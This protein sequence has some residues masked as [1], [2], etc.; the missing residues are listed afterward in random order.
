MCAT[1]LLLLSVA[2]ATPVAA[3]YVPIELVTL[4][5]GTSNVVRAVNDGG[6]VAAATSGRA[7]LLTRTG[8]QLFQDPAAT[9]YSVALGINA[10]GE[11]VGFFNTTSAVRAFRG[12]R[13]AG[14]VPLTPL[15]GDSASQAFAINAAG[16]AV[17]FSSGPAG[18]RAVLWSRSG[19]VQEL[20]VLLPA[21]AATRALAINDA[22]DVVGV[23]DAPNGARAVR[24]QGGVVQDLGA[25]PG[26][27]TSQAVA[28]NRKGE[29][30]GSSGDADGPRRAVLWMADGTIRDLGTLPGG[31]RS[32]ALGIS[33]RTEV[34]GSSDTG[35]GTHAFRWTAG[36]GMQDLNDLL[37]SR[38][39]FV[40][41]EAVASS[42]QGVI[43]ALGE[44]DDGGAD[45]HGHDERPIRVF[46][47]VPTP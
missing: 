21:G 6:E 25:L 32:R 39:G 44:D 12:L 3:Q 37:T 40:L 7:V 26:H 35:H 16:Q 33:D 4:P 34:V 19:T 20:P 11:T 47:L 28:I 31:T 2:S 38:T 13:T 5:Q 15:V 45:A 18:V 8:L 41:T 36:S 42:P 14:I 46:L 23:S 17:G 9:D 22:G 24:W 27:S 43:V 30:A 1:L 10:A 29:I